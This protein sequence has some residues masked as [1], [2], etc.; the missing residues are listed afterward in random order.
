MVRRSSKCTNETSPTA[1]HCTTTYIFDSDRMFPCFC[2]AKTTFL[3]YNLNFTFEVKTFQS[4][5]MLLSNFGE[6]VQIVASVFCSRNSPQVV[7]CSWTPSVWRFDAFYD[8]INM[9]QSI[10]GIFWQCYWLYASNLLQP[11]YHLGICLSHS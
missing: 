1:L 5:R 10:R 2:F 8:Q 7:F 9:G 4:F 3:S 6:P 11:H